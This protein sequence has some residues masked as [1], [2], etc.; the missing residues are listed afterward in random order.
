M[1]KYVERIATESVLFTVE[2]KSG[3]TVAKKC[4]SLESS[5]PT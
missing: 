4:P 3:D 2:K 1:K 5:I